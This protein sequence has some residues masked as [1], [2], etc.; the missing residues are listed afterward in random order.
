MTPIRQMRPRKRAGMDRSRKIGMSAGKG[1][2]HGQEYRRGSTV[3]KG[4]YGCN[5]EISGCLVE[6]HPGDCDRDGRLFQ[7]GVRTGHRRDRETHGREVAGQGFRGA[8]RLPE[9]LLR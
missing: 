1:N 7:A 8:E 6:E 2:G 3:W 5:A 9:E 4:E